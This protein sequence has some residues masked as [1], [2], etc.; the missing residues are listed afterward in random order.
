MKPAILIV[1]DE[2]PTCESLARY[3]SGG[4]KTYTAYNGRQA[5]RMIEENS[6][7]ALILSDIKMPEMDGMEL[8]EKLTAGNND[9]LVIFMT[10]FSDI[11][12][13]VKAIRKGAY[14]YLTKPLDLEK[15]D[16]SIKNAMEY[17]KLMTENILLKQR[18]KEGIKT[19]PLIGES[20]KIKEV[21]ELIDRISSTAATVLIQGESGVGKELAVNLVHYNSPVAEGPLIKVNCSVFAEGVLESELFGHEKGAFTGALHAKKGRFELADGGTIFLDEIGDTPLS[22]QIKL[23]RVLQEKEFER[24][25][26]DKTIKVNVRVISATNKNL[27]ELINQ[28]KFRD[29]LFYRLRVV[30]ITIPPLR[31]RKEDIP[32]LVD[33]YLKQLAGIHNKKIQ[34]ISTGAMEIIQSHDWPGNVRELINCIESAI[35]LCRGDIITVDSLPPYIFEESTIDMNKSQDS[36]YEIERRAIL[37]TLDRVSG[38]KAAAA[39]IL[40]IGL[41]TLYRK[42]QEY[43]VTSH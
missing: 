40:G 23:L 16:V 10:A 24:V 12:S 6:D 14:D 18:I 37:D 34:G 5:V 30:T 4:Y 19:K 29:D 33:H 22:T 7:I 26:G 42:L 43:G 27:E 15:L 20:G 11:E 32:L 2:R 9:A 1:D 8:L 41:R 21:R 28:K 13:A 3:L 35:V 31:E 38:N 17:R 39:R 25:G 36:L